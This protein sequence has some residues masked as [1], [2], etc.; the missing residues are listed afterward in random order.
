MICILGKNDYRFT[1]TVVTIGKFDAFHIGHRALVECMESYRDRGMKTVVLRLDIRNG[2]KPLRTETE[3]IDLLARMGV[4]IYI[5]HDFTERDAR[6]SAEDFI[7]N[8]LV[9]RL[10]AKAVV[11]GEDFRFG[12]ERRGDAGLLT[13]EGAKCGFET[14]VLEKVSYDGEVV[15]SSRIRKAL[16]SGRAEEASAMMEGEEFQ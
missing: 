7:K 8:V 11:V 14:V 5:R 6:M 12:F 9:D 2:E 3:R 15:S 4:D 13:R 16:G 1:D 10:G